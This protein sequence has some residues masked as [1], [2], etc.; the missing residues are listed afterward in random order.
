MTDNDL[1]NQMQIIFFDLKKRYLDRNYIDCSAEQALQNQEKL[2]LQGLFI[3]RQYDILLQHQ[4]E[5]LNQRDKKMLGDD[6]SITAKTEAYHAR[7]SFNQEELFY[8]NRLGYYLF[9]SKKG[10]ATFQEFVNFLSKFQFGTY[11]ERLAIFLEVLCE[12]NRSAPGRNYRPPNNIER[13]KQGRKSLTDGHYAP[14]TNESDEVEPYITRAQFEEVFRFL[15]VQRKPIEKQFIYDKM[16][17]T[18]K[19]IIEE[20]FKLHDERQIANESQKL[21][22]R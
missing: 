2:N 1:Y 13:V 22:Y 9:V 14:P 3:D 6:M 10:N 21:T 19:D 4:G 16:P 20:I 17:K 5:S 8:M 7:Q 15:H 12:E 11:H 18:Y